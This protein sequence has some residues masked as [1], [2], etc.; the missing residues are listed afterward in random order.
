MD[1]GLGQAASQELPRELCLLVQQTS[2]MQ[3][4]YTVRGYSYKLF[5]WVKE[6]YVFIVDTITDVPIPI[7]SYIC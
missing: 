3:N 4:C 7:Y 5:K 2:K 6:L 1:L